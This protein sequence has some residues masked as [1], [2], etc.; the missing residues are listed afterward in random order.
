MAIGVKE[1]F[2]QNKDYAA[3]VQVSDI[4]L[5]SG[6]SFLAGVKEK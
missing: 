6:I 4:S 5:K 2:W 3:E 1:V